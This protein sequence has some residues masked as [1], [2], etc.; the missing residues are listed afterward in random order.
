MPRRRFRRRNPVQDLRRSRCRLRRLRRCRFRRRRQARPKRSAS[1]ERVTEIGIVGAR[2]LQIR[3]TE[4]GWLRGKLWIGLRGTT[5]GGVICVMLQRGSF[6]RV[7]GSGNRS[8]PPPPP[9]A[10]VLPAGSFAT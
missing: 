5:M 4:Q 3:R 2:N 8:P 6:P 10:L 7:A 9:P 1:G